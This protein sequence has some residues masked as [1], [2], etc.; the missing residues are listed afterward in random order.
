MP[1]LEDAPLESEME[2]FER[3]MDWIY[4]HYETLKREYPN[5]FVAVFNQTVVAHSSDI[6]SLIASVQPRLGQ[7]V[8]NIA[9]KFIYAEPPA[10]VLI[11]NEDRV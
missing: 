8:G 3:D 1:L 9:I 6:Q 7:Q 11:P 4:T 5:E 2:R 10:I